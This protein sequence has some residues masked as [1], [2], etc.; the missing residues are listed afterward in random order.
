M[1]LAFPPNTYNVGNFVLE[2]TMKYFYI[3]Q[4]YIDF[5]LIGC[6]MN[7]GDHCPECKKYLRDI[8][9]H[10]PYKY[11]YILTIIIRT[12]GSTQHNT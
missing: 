8:C 1:I 7:S 9:R 10:S 12:L 4:G 5:V 3:K 6:G 11:Y 2:S